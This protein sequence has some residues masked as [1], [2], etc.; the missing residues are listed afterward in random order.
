MHVLYCIICVGDI[1]GGVKG[2]IDQTQCQYTCT[3]TERAL[4]VH[5]E[6]MF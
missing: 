4:H 6:S 3:D 2:V 1:K 5:L